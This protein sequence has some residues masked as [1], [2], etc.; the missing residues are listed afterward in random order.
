MMGPKR[1]NGKPGACKVKTE[2]RRENMITAE[3]LHI[4]WRQTVIDFGGVPPVPFEDVR[5]GAYERY[6]YMATLLIEQLRKS[7]PT[8]VCLCGSTRFSAAFRT[9]NL[10][11]TLNGKI[12]L[13]IGIDTRSDEDLLLAGTIT[14]ADKEKLDE[15]HLRK[16]DIADEI[17]VL[18][19]GGYVGVSTQHEINYAKLAGKVVRWLEP[20]GISDADH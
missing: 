8:I 2:R 20:E 14:P 13:S 7:R 18:N 11:E 10:T 12:V 3:M 5:G 6:E 17:L 1:R 15:L 4:A 16:I 9:A 19:V